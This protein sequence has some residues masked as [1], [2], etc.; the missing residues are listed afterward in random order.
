M[1]VVAAGA[2]LPVAVQCI[3]PNNF[4]MYSDMAAL[5]FFFFGVIVILRKLYAI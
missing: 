1:V 5:F 2:L 4:G 3:C